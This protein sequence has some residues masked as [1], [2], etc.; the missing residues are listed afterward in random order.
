MVP[1]RKAAREAEAATIRSQIPSFKDNESIQKFFLN[2]VHMGEEMLA[3]G[4]VANGVEHLANAVVVCSQP[5]Q[6][7]SVLS[8]TLPPH[9]FQLLIQHLAIAGRQVNKPLA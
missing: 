7:L 9:V 2:E 8:N 5:Q 4:D 1:G 6:L 3:Q